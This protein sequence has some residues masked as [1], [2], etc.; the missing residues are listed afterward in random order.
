MYSKSLYTVH[1]FANA[2]YAVEEGGELHTTFQI[3]V[4]GNTDLETLP[5]L[6]TITSEQG[7]AS[8]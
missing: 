3:N 2:S 8:E 6:G 4:K 7:T 5:I 1:G